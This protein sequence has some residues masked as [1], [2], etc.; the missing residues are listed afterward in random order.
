M[1]E[2]VSEGRVPATHTYIC[3]VYIFMYIAVFG[4]I[5]VPG[6]ASF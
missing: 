3:I 4:Y 6:M 2:G 5:R 1:I